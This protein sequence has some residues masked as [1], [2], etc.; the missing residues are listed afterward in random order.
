MSHIARIKKQ[1]QGK[2]CRIDWTDK[3]INEDTLKII[4]EFVLQTDIVD[5][6]RHG[7]GILLMGPSCI[8]KT[9]FGNFLKSLDSFV[10][11]TRMPKLKL[12]DNLIK[13][14]KASD[15]KH[16]VTKGKGVLVLGAPWYIWKERN[17]LRERQPEWDSV[18]FKEKY[19]KCIKKLE[20][21]NIPHIFIDNRNDFPIL[22]KSS[23]L[24]ML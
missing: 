17:D 1:K 23:F 8:G 22:D 24:A 10:G 7:G 4:N 11:V 21:Y 3:M 13:S 2:I 20:E 16:D 19:A 5:E 18:K 15:I 6:A 12:S 14:E 9:T